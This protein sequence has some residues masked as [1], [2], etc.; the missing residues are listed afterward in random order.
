MMRPFLSQGSGSRQVAL[1]AI[2]I[3]LSSTACRDSVAVPET[4]RP[5]ETPLRGAGAVT[6]EKWQVSVIASPLCTELVPNAINDSDVVV[7][8]CVTPAGPVVAFRWQNGVLST[9]PAVPGGSASSARA[10]NASGNA[11]GDITVGSRGRA[12]LWTAQGAVAVLP[13]LDN[14][15][16]RSEVAWAINRSNVIVGEA[17]CPSVAVMWT[18]GNGAWSASSVGTLGGSDRATGI[19]DDRVI[20]GTSTDAGGEGRAWRKPPAG[21]M[22]VLQ[23]GGE[24]ADDAAA[25]DINNA[26]TIVGDWMYYTSHDYFRWQ[27]STGMTHLGITGGTWTPGHPYG[28]SISEKER[29]VVTLQAH[30]PFTM[31][32]SGIALLPLPAGSKNGSVTDVNTCGTAV[33]FTYPVRTALLWRRLENGRPVCD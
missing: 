29:L 3:A 7:G 22:E 23:A 11:V 9:M 19:N 21:A 24:S 30:V 5:R 20:V 6:S 10:V 28:I 4:V 14:I 25:S 15:E 1:C 2:L 13:A 27:P 16:T 8:V 12:F 26:G 33:G 32:G 17:C 18:Y 31:R